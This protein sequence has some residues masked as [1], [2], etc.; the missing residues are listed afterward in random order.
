MNPTAHVSEQDVFNMRSSAHI[1]CKELC[2]TVVLHAS[3]QL[4]DRSRQKSLMQ[5]RVR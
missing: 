3:S 5:L 4:A 2:I 1:A